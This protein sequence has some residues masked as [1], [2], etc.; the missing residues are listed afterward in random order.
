MLLA[1]LLDVDLCFATHES[2]TEQYLPNSETEE[3]SISTHL[4]LM[5]VEKKGTYNFNKAHSG[6]RNGRSVGYSSIKCISN[7]VTEGFRCLLT[8]TYI[9][10]CKSR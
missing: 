7:T 1:L 5:P 3:L 8:N 10:T 9:S 6:C 2:G 4:F